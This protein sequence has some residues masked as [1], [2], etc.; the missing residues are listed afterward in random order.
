MAVSEVFL[1]F[2][3]LELTATRRRIALSLWNPWSK[4]PE[5]GPAIALLPSRAWLVGLGH[6]GQAYAWTYSWLPFS[7][8][9]SPELWLVDDER[10]EKPNVETGLLSTDNTI[11]D[12]K[13]RTMSTWL[14]G[15]GICSRIIE[16]RI[17]KTFKVTGSEPRVLSEAL[18]TIRFVSS[19]RSV[20]R[21]SSMQASEIVRTIS[22]Q[23]PCER[24]RIPAAQRTYGLQK[25][26]TKCSRIA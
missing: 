10:I 4:S 16:R 13:T 18:T 1:D 9:M 19:W 11:G 12:F 7:R 22:I 26:R 6:L 14:S 15:K 20:V 5:P 3:A 2:A 8:G 21:Q 17:D 23:L 25:I 24:G